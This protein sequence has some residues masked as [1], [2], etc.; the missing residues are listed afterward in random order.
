MASAPKANGNDGYTFLSMLIV[1]SISMVMVASLWTMVMNH[2]EVANIVANT[3]NTAQMA[4]G[5]S[6]A[7]MIMLQ[8]RLGNQQGIVASALQPCLNT[9]N[10]NTIPQLIPPSREVHLLAKAIMYEKLVESCTTKTSYGVVFDLNKA[11]TTVY[12]FGI[13]RVQPNQETVC[14]I[15]ILFGESISAAQGTT[16]YDLKSDF[17]SYTKVRDALQK[18]RTETAKGVPLLSLQSSFNILA[19]ELD[20]KAQCYIYTLCETKETKANGSEVLYDR[21]ISYQLMEIVVSDDFQIEVSSLG[22][23]IMSG[24]VGVQKRALCMERIP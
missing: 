11:P 7:Q 3:N 13:E 2:M 16:L 23:R 8:D 21:Q 6:D 19:S 5:V 1:L 4:K 24:E 9:T 17:T 12:A 18:I 15:K 14:T 20:D 10:S 22:S